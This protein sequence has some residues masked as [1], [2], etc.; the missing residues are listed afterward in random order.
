MRPR[1]MVRVPADPPISAAIFAIEKDWFK[2]WLKKAELAYDGEV[3]RGGL[4]LW[5]KE[6]CTVTKEKM[7]SEGWGLVRDV[8]RLFMDHN[9]WKI[10]QTEAARKADPDY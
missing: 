9:T 2:L 3:G 1:K 5:V 6:T 8:I 10:A 7:Q 4:R